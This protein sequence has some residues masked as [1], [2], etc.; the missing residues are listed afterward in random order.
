V[1]F[2]FEGTFNTAK[3][4]WDCQLETLCSIAQRTCQP[5]QRQFIDIAAQAQA[6]N[7]RI[8]I[9]LNVRHITPAVIEKTIIMIRNYKRLQVG[10]YEYGEIQVFNGA[11]C[12][13]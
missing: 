2:T 8:C 3:L 4:I 7:R 10:R 11:N 5:Q 9:G 13:E 12:A 1:R 6:G